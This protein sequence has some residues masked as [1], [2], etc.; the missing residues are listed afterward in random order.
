MTHSNKSNNPNNKICTCPELRVYEGCGNELSNEGPR[1]SAAP[2]VTCCT[3][4]PDP[5]GAISTIRPNLASDSISWTLL[6]CTLC[7]H[8]GYVKQMVIVCWAPPTGK[9]CKDVPLV[10]KWERLSIFRGERKCI[11]YPSCKDLKDNSHATKD[12][13]QLTAWRISRVDQ[14]LLRSST[15]AQKIQL[16]CRQSWRMSLH[17]QI[18]YKSNELQKMS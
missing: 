16:H 10:S 5:N 14:G 12:R 13:S 17:S 1:T 9:G 8:M 15:S 7:L 3:W 11:S 2:P 4:R 6:P 18:H